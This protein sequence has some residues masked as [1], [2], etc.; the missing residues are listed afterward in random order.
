[1]I[2]AYVS[3]GVAVFTLI[4]AIFIHSETR[5]TLGRMNAI[6][7]TLPGAYDVNRLIGDL[8]KTGELRGR[9]VCDAP[10]NTHIGWSLLPPEIPWRKRIKNKIWRFIRT[11]ANY[12]S[13][14]IYESMVEESK[15]GKWEITSG[16]KTSSAVNELLMQGWEPFSMTS[17]GKVWL[18]KHLTI[19]KSEAKAKS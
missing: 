14:D 13:G 15:M 16:W 3:L 2:V 4:L 11:V 7:D 6:T 8:E 17:D 9:V 12:W 19:R 10:K 5:D 1:M 18:R